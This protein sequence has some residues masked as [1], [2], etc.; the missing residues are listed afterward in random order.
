MEILPQLQTKFGAFRQIEIPMNIKDLK[1]G[2]AMSD[3]CHKIPWEGV[4]DNAA[5]FRGANVR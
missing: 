2:N 5:L 4:A 3:I 1:Y